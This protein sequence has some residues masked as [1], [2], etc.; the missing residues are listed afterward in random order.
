[1]FGVSEQSDISKIISN[2]N[3]IGTLS[4]G[5]TLSETSMTVI[6]HNSWSGMLWRTYNRENRKGTMN[7]IEEVLNEATFLL[8]ASY[9]PELVTSLNQA[10]IGFETLTQTYKGDY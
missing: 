9:S 1:M 2:L 10:L 4:A 7:K 3:V 8:E 6:E 5:K